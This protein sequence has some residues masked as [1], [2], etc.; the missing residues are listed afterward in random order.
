MT[1]ALELSPELRAA[2]RLACAALGG[3]ELGT[4][5]DRADG[6]ELPLNPHAIDVLRDYVRRV[7]DYLRARYPGYDEDEPGY[8]ETDEDAYF[9]AI[10]TYRN[11]LV[12]LVAGVV[13]DTFL[14]GYRE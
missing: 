13:G 8:S 11:K 3:H 7:E 2:L 4:L 12:M 10:E 9:D 1:A 5:L 6:R 14:E